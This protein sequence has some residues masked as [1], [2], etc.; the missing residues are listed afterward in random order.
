MKVKELIAKL[1]K[2]EAADDCEVFV[3]T[4]S[5]R[6]MVPTI[7][8]T[9]HADVYVSAVEF[10]GRCVAFDTFPPRPHP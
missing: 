4:R 2:L 6:D 1:K 7:I 9:E 3:V 10:V 8:S 5:G